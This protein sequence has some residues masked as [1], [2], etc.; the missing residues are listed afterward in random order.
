[1][2]DD[3]GQGGT[4]GE[5]RGTDGGRIAIIFGRHDRDQDVQSGEKVVP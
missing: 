3:E 1:M 5:G 2:G 4:T